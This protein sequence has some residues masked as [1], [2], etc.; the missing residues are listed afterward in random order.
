MTDFKV[1]GRDI[2]R[3]DGVPKAQGTAKY[4]TDFFIPGMLQ[5]RIL[6]SRHP[7]ARILD[8]RT[9][10]AERLPG[11]RAVATHKNTPLVR[12]GMNISDQILFDPEKVRYLGDEVA[13]VAATDL[14]IVE[15]ALSLIEVD[16][17][18]LPA[19]FD[20]IEA[21]LP[22]APLIH[23]NVGDYDTTFDV[24]GQ[25]GNVACRITFT[26]GDI[27]AGLREADEVFDHTFRTHQTHQTY[28]ESHTALAIPDGQ[29]GLTIR[30]STQGVFYSQGLI[31]KVLK[32]P[33][34][35]VRVIGSA[36]GGGFGGKKPRVEMYAALL[37]LQA[38]RPVRMQFTRDE[39]FIA[40][41]PRH[42][43]VIE[44]RSG[45]KRD[46]RLTA[47]EAKLYYDTGAYTGH[48]PMIVACGAIYA[49][50]V[51]RIP[52]VR[53]VGYTVYTNKTISGAFRGYGNPQ[54]TFAVESHMDAV[55]T[56]LG[57]DPLDLRRINGMEHGDS[58]V[59]GQKMP[60]V[61]LKK[62]LED[63][64]RFVNWEA[65]I[66]GGDGNHPVRR[67]RGIACGMHVSGGLSSSAI[68]KVMEDGTIQ[69]VSGVIEV[70]AG[71][72]TMAAQVAAEELGIDIEDV[73]VVP[74]DTDA[75][76]FE[77]HTAASRVTYNVGNVVR[78][79]TAD[80]KRQLLERASDLLEVPVEDLR[81]ENKQVLMPGA[82]GKGMTFGKIV[83][84]AHVKRGG[85]ILGRGVFDAVG[86]PVIPDCQDGSPRGGAATMTYFTH[87]ADVEV[88]VETGE[89]K[90]LRLV[91]SHDVGQ[92]I[93]QV[94]IV[95]Q[96]QGGATQGIGYALIEEVVYSGG[97][98]TNPTL[99][100]Y[101]VPNILDIPP[102]ECRFIEEPEP[103]G[104]FG[105]KG[106]SEGVLVPTAAAIANAV[107]DAV[108]VRVTDLPVTPEKVLSGL[109][110]GAENVS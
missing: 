35:K 29:G 79:A 110:A 75:T 24:K 95:G 17:E 3:I 39:E 93:N 9:E 80:A 14:D 77:N 88:D 107:Y 11:V 59:N 50:G 36:V 104:P 20:P 21:V 89:V 92:I 105:A 51:Y 106:F 52:H 68:V 91:C 84:A 97:V 108:G 76:P 45:V 61:W 10:K 2:P 53:T 38:G 101:K 56:E 19:V 48:G 7:H 30:V 5:G 43:T 103:T 82:P 33:F 100:D 65:G 1:I 98:V 66:P 78:L 94:A 42:P 18:E 62:T 31:S 96:L 4:T 73:R 54:S 57:I 70:G 28:L 55:A 67:G 90:V 99:M 72:V 22:D 69:V 15:E 58:L 12:Y 26:Q 46:G 47:R 63:A 41:L 49:K 27:E 86:P 64:A 25:Q 16:Y 83:K 44:I 32:L 74:A 85:P 87:I 34:S 13:A 37:A 8:I 6:R 81:V 40:G 71:Q 109:H 23:E 102:I 60:G